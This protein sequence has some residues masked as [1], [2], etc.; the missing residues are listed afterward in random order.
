M[1]Q[2]SNPPFQIR[3]DT[4]STLRQTITKLK[5]PECLLEVRKAS[6]QAQSQWADTLLQCDQARDELELV[7]LSAIRNKLKE[8]EQDLTT[9]AKSLKQALENLK[10]IKQALDAAAA[11]VG[12]VAKVLAVA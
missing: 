4:L 6:T 10:K 7:Q 11:F 1:A 12:I 2:A 9:G 3:D 5:S 8:N